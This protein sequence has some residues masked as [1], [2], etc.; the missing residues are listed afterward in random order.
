MNEEE[1]DK[2]KSDDLEESREII[3]MI[4]NSENDELVKHDPTRSDDLH[5]LLQ[6]KSPGRPKINDF[7][8]D[9]KKIKA[10]LPAK[11]SESA[12]S[13][14]LPDNTKGVPD[15][16]GHPPDSLAESYLG[17][18]VGVLVTVIIVLIVAI[19][20]ILYKNYQ[21]EK[22]N[23]LKTVDS[24]DQTEEDWT[25][26]TGQP[27]TRLHQTGLSD[28]LYQTG[29]TDPLYPTYHYSPTSTMRAPYTHYTNSNH[30][31]TTELIYSRQNIFSRS[32]D[33]G[34]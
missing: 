25:D 16:P 7:S 10:S 17:L 14:K 2:S 5:I 27:Q 1:V 32:A 28:P 23:C 4:D 22:K 33:F 34:V 18:S 3:P 19:V 21:Y 8:E 12:T 26:S 9:V 30:Y 20:F 29:Q 13:T 24:Y 15:Y 31:A 11:Q 6:K